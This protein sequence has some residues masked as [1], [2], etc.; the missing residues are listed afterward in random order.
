MLN[1]I[2]LSLDQHPALDKNTINAFDVMNTIFTVIFTIE[3]VLKIIG[4]GISVFVADKFNLFDSAIVLISLIEMMIQDEGEKGGAF[5][6]LRAFR[7]FR[8]LKLFRTG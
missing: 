6:A 7:L 8:I 4:L 5:S 3:V 2:L 1:T